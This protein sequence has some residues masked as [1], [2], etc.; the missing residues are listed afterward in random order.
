MYN[1]L[2]SYDENL[3]NGPAVDWNRDGVFP[4]VQFSGEPKFSFLGIPLYLPLGIPAGPLLSSAYV[5]VA[6]NAGFCMPV[7]KTVRS[8]KWQSHPWPNVL[9]LDI[10]GD[11]NDGQISS[12]EGT[13]EPRPKV[14]VLPLSLQD[15]S[16]PH[17]RSR[18]S[19]TNAFGVP[20]MAT[21]EWSK[22][23]SRLNEFAYA[24]GRCTVLSF[25]G[26]R[27]PHSQWHDFLED[28]S[29]IAQQAAQCVSRQGG[30]VLEMN[31][32]CP[33]EAG[34]PIYT[35][36]NA[37][38]ETLRAAAEGLSGFSQ[39]RLIIKL[40]VVPEA[41]IL[42]TV[43]LVA[44][45]AHGVSAINTVSATIVTSEGKRALGSGA[46]HGGVCGAAIREQALRLV[47]RLQS[48]RKSLGLLPDH[49]ALIG[50]GGIST[51][52]DVRRFLDAGAD[53]VQAATGAMWNLQFAEDCARALDVKFESRNP[54]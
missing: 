31:V 21:Q 39:I 51:V 19:I 17:L 5:N 43:E 41:N 13:L 52:Q 18:L 46:E 7:Y 35:D 2:L 48:A 14:R 8:M 40:G 30:R 33:N 26:T 22:D 49:F 34:A 23:Y 27:K 4:N 36:V 11:E 6:L 45:Y 20:S 24:H 28:T 47:A 38:E 54:K 25:Q 12:T 44:R 15:L 37:L 50:V 9:R 3:R 10:R 29:L 42:R 32:S 16:D 53:V 1:P